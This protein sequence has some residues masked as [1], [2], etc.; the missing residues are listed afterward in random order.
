M[1]LAIKVWSQAGASLV[2]AVINLGLIFGWW[3]WT[4]AQCAAINTVY[5]SVM[6]V[7]RQMFSITP[8]E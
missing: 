4:T 7:L 6:M 8:V 5:A 3:T 2:I 1:K